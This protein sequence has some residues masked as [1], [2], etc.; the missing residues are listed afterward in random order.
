MEKELKSN[1]CNEIIQFL[2][3]SSLSWQSEHISYLV[4]K[5]KMPGSGIAS[6]LSCDLSEISWKFLLQNS[7]LKKELIQAIMSLQGVIEESDIL[8]LIQKD[9]DED[10]EIFRLVLDNCTPALSNEKITSLCQQALNQKKLKYVDMLILQGATPNV[11]ELADI[12]TDQENIP[13]CMNIMSHVKSAPAVYTM[14]LLK[15]LKK[16]KFSVAEEW[17]LKDSKDSM[18][19]LSAILKSDMIDDKDYRKDYISFIKNIL[20]TKAKSVNEIC[21]IIDTI[22][23]QDCI[24][25]AVKIQLLLSILIEN[26]ACIQ[27]C[28]FPKNNSTTLLHIVTKLAIDHYSGNIYHE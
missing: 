3:K 8:I 11:S 17:V 23:E 19:D 4:V 6:T 12:M 28:A 14:M 25:H 7:F 26:H 27:Y 21:P 20:G 22:L 24:H 10:S 2:L 5:S 13:A 15:L 16:G 1:E 9:Q 18:I